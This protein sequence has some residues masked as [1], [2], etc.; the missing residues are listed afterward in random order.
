VAA[1]GA[2]GG[3]PGIAGTGTVVG[4]VFGEGRFGGVGRG[5]GVTIESAA[6]GGQKSGANGAHL[7]EAALQDGGVKMPLA[8]DVGVV[9]GGAQSLA[10]G[11]D[12]VDAGF[13]VEGVKAAVE[14]GAAG[15]TD[16]A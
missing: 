4:G 14:H 12:V 11:V 7:L 8:A 2:I 1:Q 9:P 16:S 6:A 10:P 13:G 3:I 5:A 15:N